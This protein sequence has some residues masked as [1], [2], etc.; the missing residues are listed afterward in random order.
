MNLDSDYVAWLQQVPSIKGQRDQSYWDVPGATKRPRQA[1]PAASGDSSGAS[2]PLRLRELASFGKAGALVDI[3][4]N[5]GKCSPQELASQ[6]VRA[7]AAQ[8]TQ[9]VLTGCSVKGSRDACRICD[10]WNGEA[11]LRRAQELLGAAARN[12]MA[13]AGI[14]ALPNLTFTAGVHPHDAKSCD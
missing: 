10:E 12:E 13:S 8:V 6:L 4:A 7:A 2:G 3:G 5:L 14:R 1:E 9:I 11:G